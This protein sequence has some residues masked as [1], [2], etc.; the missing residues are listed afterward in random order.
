M[1]SIDRIAKAKA[2]TLSV[3]EQVN[4]LVKGEE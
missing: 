4:A 2:D 1:I 3:Y